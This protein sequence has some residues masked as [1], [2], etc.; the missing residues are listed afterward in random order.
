M[1]NDME[2][3]VK[4][5]EGFEEPLNE[6]EDDEIEEEHLETNDED[7]EEETL[8]EDGS[9]WEHFEKDEDFELQEVNGMFCIT[10]EDTKFHYGSHVD[11]DSASDHIESLRNYTSQELP[12]QESYKAAISGLFVRLE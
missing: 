3:Y 7:D 6:E 8:T 10:G 5:I 2:N 12:T 11:Y 9:F 4:L 1:H